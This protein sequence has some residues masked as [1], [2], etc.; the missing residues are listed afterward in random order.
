M[1]LVDRHRG[2]ALIPARPGREID[3]VGP[4][5][6]LRARDHRG[7]LR[8]RFRGKRIRVRLERDQG[9]GRPGQLEFVDSPVVAL[10][11]RKD[12]AGAIAA[13]R[14]LDADALERVEMRAG[15]K[16]SDFLAVELPR[17]AAIAGAH[18]PSYAV[19]TPQMSRAYSR[20]VRS[21]ENHA[22]LA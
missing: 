10:G 6:G 13:V 8:S 15:N 7:G 21:A 3:A 22:T 9:Y 19:G 2:A 11:D 17:L 16:L 20:M 18:A 14:V 1:H 4:G 5:I 12:G